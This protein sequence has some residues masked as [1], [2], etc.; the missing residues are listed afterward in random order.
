MVS[1]PGSLVSLPSSDLHNLAK[2]D[3]TYHYFIYQ[4]THLLNDNE[5]INC[6]FFHNYGDLYNNDYFISGLVLG[7]R[8]K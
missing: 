8:I 3:H 1:N 4:F 2:E 5:N 6:C 7:V